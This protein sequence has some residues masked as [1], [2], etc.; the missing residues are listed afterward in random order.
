MLKDSSIILQVS[1][2]IALVVRGDCNFTTKAKIAQAGG[3]AGLIVINDEEG[4]STLA[5]YIHYFDVFFRCLRPH[6]LA[7]FIPLGFLMDVTLLE[8]HRSCA[9]GLWE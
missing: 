7:E 3:A 8:L 4:G 1:G 6:I 5:T 2:S 9:D